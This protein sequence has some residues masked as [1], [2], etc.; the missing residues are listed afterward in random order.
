MS[1]F[2][3]VRVAAGGRIGFPVSRNGVLRTGLVAGNFTVTLTNPA[4]T[5]ST[6]LV[7]TENPQKAGDYY[8]DVPPSFLAAHG[9]GDYSLLIEVSA[10]GPNLNAVLGGRLPVVVDDMDSFLVKDFVCP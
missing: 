1:D 6:A 2:N 5:A 7:V 3:Q 4:R 9:V 8:C 10:N